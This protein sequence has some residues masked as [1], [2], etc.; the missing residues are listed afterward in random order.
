M[1]GQF[2]WVYTQSTI[3]GLNDNSMYIFRN[4][5]TVFH[6]GYTT[7]HSHLQCQGFQ[8]LYI[9]ADILSFLFLSSFNTSHP[10]GCEVVAHGFDLHL[11][12]ISDTEHLFICLLATGC[13]LWRNIYSSPLPI[14]NWVI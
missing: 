12:M 5:H 8:F 11:P 6:S 9:S 4:C 10:N 3:A 13:L 2:L 1:S 14:F 7:L